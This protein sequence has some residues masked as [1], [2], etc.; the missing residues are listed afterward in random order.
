M[1]QAFYTVNSAATPV[2][3]SATANVSYFQEQSWAYLDEF[4]STQDP[5]PS[6]LSPT[7]RVSRQ[8]FKGGTSGFPSLY[9]VAYNVGSPVGS[10]TYGIRQLLGGSSGVL[11]VPY[12]ATASTTSPFP[13]GFEV[14][15]LGAAGARQIWT[16]IC[17]MA[18]SGARSNP[19]E[20]SY[21]GYEYSGM[22]AVNTPD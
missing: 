9:S 12:Y 22:T 2:L 4:Q 19:T 1:T 3:N 10:P 15:M 13:G 16:R 18:I 8:V 6:P 11:T 5:S 7:G 14:Y 21:A 20:M 17:L